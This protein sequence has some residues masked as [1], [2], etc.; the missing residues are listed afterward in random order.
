[1][2]VCKSIQGGLQIGSRQRMG[3]LKVRVAEL[4]YYSMN[5]LS[6]RHSRG[7]QSDV[8]QLVVE[9]TIHPHFIIK[10]RFDHF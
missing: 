8:A 10:R 6:M 2:L 3:D 5:I 1:M 7:G 9:S 4:V